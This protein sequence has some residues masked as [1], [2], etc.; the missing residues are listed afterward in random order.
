M[1]YNSIPYKTY[2]DLLRSMVHLSSQRTNALY[3]G[4]SFQAQPPVAMP[5]LCIE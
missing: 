2:Q 5:Q 3:F 1:P 4:S